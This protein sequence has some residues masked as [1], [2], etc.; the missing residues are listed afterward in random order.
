M[1]VRL[2]SLS[3]EIGLC[4]IVRQTDEEIPT[5]KVRPTVTMAEQLPGEHPRLLMFE[6]SLNVMVLIVVC[7]LSGTGSLISNSRINKTRSFL[8]HGQQESFTV[9]LPSTTY[10]CVANKCAGHIT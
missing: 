3:T 2:F 1:H 9:S 8:C 7:K 5:P 10:P 6:D 4:M